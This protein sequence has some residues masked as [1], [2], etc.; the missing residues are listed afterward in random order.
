MSREGTPVNASNNIPHS[1]WESERERGGC[2]CV[3]ERERER[4]KEI[5]VCKWE[6]VYGSESNWMGI[7]QGQCRTLSSP[8]DRPDLRPFNH[9]QSIIGSAFQGQ[10]QVKESPWCRHKMESPPPGAIRQT[11]AAFKKLQ[12]SCAF[13]ACACVRNLQPS[14]A[15]NA[16]ACVRLMLQTRLHY[17][18]NFPR[19]TQG[20]CFFCAWYR[21]N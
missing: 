18:N 12:P 3:R 16:C 21:V 10:Y 7:T 19:K 14:C 5:N 6:C 20:S 1:K 11:S 8:L 13:N 2:L 9:V 17:K 15:F 4:E